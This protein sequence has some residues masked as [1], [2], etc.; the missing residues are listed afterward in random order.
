[1]SFPSP[2]GVY[3]RENEA[4]FRLAVEIALMRVTERAS[5]PTSM[6]SPRPAEG[7]MYFD[8]DLGIPIWYF[9]GWVDAAGA[10]V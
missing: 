1:V 5:G 9:G 10:S 8:T 7:Q 3:S 6:R 2:S 4:Q